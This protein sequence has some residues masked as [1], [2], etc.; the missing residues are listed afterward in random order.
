LIIRLSSLGDILLTTPAIRCLRQAYPKARIDVLIRAQY[1]ELLADN[2][3]LSHLIL[4]PDQSDFATLRKTAAELRGRYD[5]VM[6]LHTGLRSFFLRRRLRAARILRY[7]KKRLQRWVLVRLKRNIYG[8]EFNVPIA[9]MR[10]MAK[11]GVRDDGGGLEWFAA[12]AQRDAFLAHCGLE[13]IPDPE[14][15]ALCPGASHFTKRWPLEKWR[16]LGKRLLDAGEPV[17]WVFGGSEDSEA[18]EYL[19]RLH[20]ERVLN[21]CGKL[22]LALSGAGI[23]LCRLA[24]THDAGPAHM[25]AAVGTP[26]VDIFG[27]TVP[28]FGFAPFRVPHRIAEKA[29]YCR[30]CSHLGYPQCPL[31]HF[32]CMKDQSV[33][34]VLKLAR[35]IA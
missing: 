19:S 14:P 13:A 32:R 11:L 34:E 5:V 25:A 8:E 9:Y 1:R 24:I 28:Q 31:G 4:F 20:P 26:V 33:D 6:D 15:I 30:P 10:A 29:L 18:G 27:S 21:F 23:S 17:L 3:H 22:S 12:T 2:P 16:E 7:R 35:E